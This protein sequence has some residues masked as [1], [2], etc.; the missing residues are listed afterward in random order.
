MR[1]EEH[2]HA[3]RHIP[4]ATTASTGISHTLLEPLAA[5]ATANTSC[6][7]ASCPLGGKC[8]ER[9]KKTSSGVNVPRWVCG[10][11]G[12]SVCARHDLDGGERWLDSRQAAGPSGDRRR[13]LRWG[14]NICRH[15]PIEIATINRNPNI[16]KYT[17]NLDR[18]Y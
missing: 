4:V 14:Y 9:E 3:R 1:G 2:A 7:L 12:V 5:V 10:A 11:T 13:P 15:T 18:D 6:S 16:F 8:V 17:P